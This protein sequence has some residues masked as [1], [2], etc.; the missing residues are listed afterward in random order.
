VHA[1]LTDT[2]NVPGDGWDISLAETLAA[3]T[4]EETVR[5]YLASVFTA[6]HG[7]VLDVSF[8]G[9]YVN[10]PSLNS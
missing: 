7:V 2:C 9:I 3:V 6:R 4:V 1:A 5:A 10:F 8:H